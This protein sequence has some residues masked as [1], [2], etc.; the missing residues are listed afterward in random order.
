VVRAARAVLAR[1]AGAMQPWDPAE[2][3]GA[4]EAARR[5]AREGRPS[6]SARRVPLYEAAYQLELCVVREEQGR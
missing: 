2:V 6:E 5:A 3:A 1:Q 4:V